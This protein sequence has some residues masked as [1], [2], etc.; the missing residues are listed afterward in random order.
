MKQKLNDQF[1]NIKTTG[2]QRG[3]N[4]FYHYHPYEATPYQALEKLFDAHPLS[5]NDRLVD[6]GCGKGR[7][8]FAAN[9]QFDA[10]AVGIE[11]NETF[12]EDAIQNRDNYVKKFLKREDKLVFHCCLAE[13]YRVNKLDNNFYFFNP[14]SIQIFMKVLQNILKSVEESEREV[15]VILYYGSQEYFYYLEDYSPFELI[16]VIRLE[17]YEKNPFERFLVYRLATQKSTSL[18]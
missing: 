13:D 15:K 7:L 5:N 14:F 18:F 17:G 9:Y 10:S 4:N 11:M 12:C 1:L 2:D 16:D 6:F 3:F 8:S